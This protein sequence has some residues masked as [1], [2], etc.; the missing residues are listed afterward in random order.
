MD[1]INLGIPEF[2]LNDHPS[3]ADVDPELFFPQEVE[4]SKTK[5]ISKYVNIAAAKKICSECPLVMDC[6]A[7]ALKNAEIG[8]WGGTTESQRELLR[9]KGNI[10]VNRRPA[11]PTSW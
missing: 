7:Y 6:L 3:C 1:N 5:I 8:I 9:K 11:T 10:S 2:I 4:I